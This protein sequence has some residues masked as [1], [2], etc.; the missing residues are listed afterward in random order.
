MVWRLG[1]SS[2]MTESSLFFT[3]Q[4]MMAVSPSTTDTLSATRF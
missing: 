2:W 1:L 4:L 3:R